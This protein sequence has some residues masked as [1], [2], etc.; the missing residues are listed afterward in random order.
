MTIASRRRE[1]VIPTDQKR[2]VA[3][4]TC[5]V[6][7][8]THNRRHLLDKTLDCLCRQTTD[9]SAIEVIVVAD[10]CDD[11]TAE[12]LRSQRWPFAL[13]VLEHA[14][15]CSAASRNA[16]AAVA[17]APVLIFLDDDVMAA[18]DL[19]EKHL[20]AHADGEAAVAIGRLAPAS[21]RG[22]PGWWRWLETQ[23]EKQYS[24]LLGGRREANGLCLYSGNC[25]INRDAFV[26]AGGFNEK[27]LHSEDIELGLRLQ[28]AELPF[29]LALDAAAEHWGYRNYQS[30]RDM[31]YTYGRWD[32]DL[33]FKAEFPSSL[34]RLREE[35][36]ERG[37]LRRRVIRSVLGDES[38]FEPFIAG[39]RALAFLSGVAR[40]RP[41]ERKAYGAIY[42]ITYWKGV[43]DGLGGLRAM[44]E[45][46]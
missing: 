31:A 19:V 43:S 27:L 37:A 26:R 32:A 10:G 40:L 25:S 24:A 42:D 29:R 41:I 1:E 38:R 3:T 28:K 33:I 39:C 21:I 7:I 2:S 15:C 17:R 4:L 18:P 35:F 30:W 36:R 8:P 12:M 11:G 13:R 20:A 5:S 6:I 34:G 23:L 45:A 44:E 14:E 22:V 16:A 9:I 46:S